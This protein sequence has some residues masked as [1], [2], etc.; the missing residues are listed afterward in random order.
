[1]ES[2][3]SLRSSAFGEQQ[4]LRRLLIY[5]VL[6]LIIGF[7]LFYIARSIA[8]IGYNTMDDIQIQN[9]LNGSKGISDGFCIFMNI[10]L[11]SLL[12][13]LYNTIPAVNWFG[14]FLLAM[15][16]LSCSL[17]AAVLAQRLGGLAGF[18]TGFAVFPF[19]YLAT[20]FNFTYTVIAYVVLA[21]AFVCV[22]YSF[23]VQD[24]KSRLFL[25]ICSAALATVAGMIRVDVIISATAAGAVFAVFLFIR[26]KKAAVKTIFVVGVML[27]LCFG[28]TAISNLLTAS[29]PVWSEYSRF[30]AVRIDMQD[31]FYP[32]YSQNKASFE[33]SGWSE[34]DYSMFYTSNIPDDPKF[35][36]TNMEQIDATYKGFN[37]FNWSILDILDSIWSFISH[38]APIVVLLVAAFILALLS[39]K[40]RLLSTAVFLFPF[41]MQAALVIIQ[42]PLARVVVPHYYITLVLL[43]CLIDVSVLRQRFA[44]RRANN[45]LRSGG[46]GSRIEAHK[47]RPFALMAFIL[48]LAISV[49]P[50]YDSFS[51]SLQLEEQRRDPHVADPYLNQQHAFDYFAQH[52]ENCYV[53]A[54]DPYFYS[55]SNNQSIFETSPR[56]YY[57]NSFS[58]GGWAVRSKQ[59]EAFKQLAGISSLP[60]DLI[61][62]DH[63]FFVT[64]TRLDPYTRYFYETYGIPVKYEIADNLVGGYQ[65]LLVKTAASMAEM[66]T[67]YA[68]NNR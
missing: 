3:T 19:I 24:K 15:L 62:N 61:D 65:V 22:A 44:G 7:I 25:W 63:I 31:R 11:G 29:D 8:Y 32:T 10:T 48:A 47:K 18:A 43:L 59:Y 20:I 56:D 55:Y 16:L 58:M 21:C 26:Y 39:S 28:L 54:M 30:N 49:Y 34:N 12:A 68:A 14:V 41:M 13:S 66:G 67:T 46:S 53:Y 2:S 45:P 36:V 50:L 35:S 6:F 4:S 5:F 33:A 52:K 38:S 27:L 40:A 57:I 17:A 51:Y 23:Y 60:H 42:R 37:R 64:V 1:M 9:L